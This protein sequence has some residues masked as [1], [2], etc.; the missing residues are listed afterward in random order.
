[1]NVPIPKVYS[2]SSRA[3]QSPIHPE[4]TMMERQAGVVLSCTIKRMSPRPRIVPTSLA[5]KFRIRHSAL[6]A[7]ID[8]MGQDE[9]RRAKELHQAPTLHNLYIVQCLQ[10]NSAVF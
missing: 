1:M 8:A 2:W 4:Y 6:P 10:R 3:S 7:T 5:V 9:Q